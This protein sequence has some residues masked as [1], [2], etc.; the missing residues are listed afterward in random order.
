MQ[1]AYEDIP[2]NVRGLV[3]LLRNQIERQEDELRKA[4]R[5]LERLL[6]THDGPRLGLVVD[7]KG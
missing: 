5:K 7:N 4:R 6:P 3:S 2:D 1:T